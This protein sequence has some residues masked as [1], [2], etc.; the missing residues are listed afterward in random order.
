MQARTQWSHG[1]HTTH[2]WGSHARRVGVPAPVALVAVAAAA[3]AVANSARCGGTAILCVCRARVATRGS[4][5]WRVGVLWWLRP[6]YRLDLLPSAGLE[7]PVR[8]SVVV[9][10][11]ALVVGAGVV[12]ATAADAV[13]VTGNAAVPSTSGTPP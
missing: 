13:E 11:N 2:G 12:A 1:T 5:V 7:Y 10:A 3:A 4:C 6:A 8:G 9:V